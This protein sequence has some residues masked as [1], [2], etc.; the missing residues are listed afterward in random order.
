MTH[1]DSDFD[2]Q[3]VVNTTINSLGETITDYQQACQMYNSDFFAGED[4]IFTRMLAKALVQ[5]FKNHHNAFWN[6]LAGV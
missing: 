5:K 2:R 3:E 6:K 4:S 1:F